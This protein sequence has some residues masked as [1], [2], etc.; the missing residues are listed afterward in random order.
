[1]RAVHGAVAQVQD[2][3]ATRLGQQGD[4][5]A[6]PDAGL[7]PVP[8]P[9][10]GRHPEQP[11]ASAGT[12]RHAT[13]V[14]ST[15]RTPAAVRNTQPSGMPA[16]PFASGRHQRSHPLPQPGTEGTRPARLP[17]NAS[18]TSPQAARHVAH[19]A[20]TYS[21]QKSSSAANPVLGAHPMRRPWEPRCG[22]GPRRAR[23]I[24]RWSRSTETSDQMIQIDGDWLTSSETRQH[25]CATRVGRFL[26]RST[27]VLR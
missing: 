21:S 25:S 13:P 23:Q 18:A 14:R 9:T 11:T 10:P 16:A 4:M 26:P 7:G 2:A 12:S 3:G 27:T 8:Q 6:R 24:D 22:S 20:S 15:N 1:M 5:Q 17:R 19:R